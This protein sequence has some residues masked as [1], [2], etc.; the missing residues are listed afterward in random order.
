MVRTTIRLE[1]SD[2]KIVR[3][4]A[5]LMSG[6]SVSRMIRQSGIR[7]ALKVLSDA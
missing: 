3:A 5:S 2:L 6:G 1:K 4:A 7:H